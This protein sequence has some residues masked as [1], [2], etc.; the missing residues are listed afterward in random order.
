MSRRKQSEEDMSEE[1]SNIDSLES[2]I[3]ASEMYLEV[4]KLSSDNFASHGY[5]IG[6]M[7][8]YSGKAFLALSD[9][10][11]ENAAKVSLREAIDAYS[12]AVS[13]CTENRIGKHFV[14]TA[15]LVIQSLRSEQ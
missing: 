12:R 5:I 10:G 1:I 7:A 9:S 3:E 2:Y 8:V 4:L 6:M 13:F 15:G 11:N 14:A